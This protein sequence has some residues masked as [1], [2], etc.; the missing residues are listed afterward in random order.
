MIVKD[1]MKYKVVSIQANAS[2]CEAM[3]QFIR[4]HI[5]TL[6]VVDDHQVLVG[7][8]L[9][10]DLLALDMPDFVHLMQ[11]YEFITD[12]GVAEN[13]PLPEEKLNQ[14]VSTI[15]EIPI[16]LEETSGLLRA[17]AMLKQ[18]SLTDILVV[19]HQGHLVGI[20]SRVDIG[21]ALLSHWRNGEKC[22]KG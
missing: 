18:H 5:G 8:L 19:D 15:M 22:S 11:N 21:I 4:H 16:S 9:I 2:I 6:P 10:S 13:A 20:A 7:M 3:G 1:C 17:A 12:F 14:S